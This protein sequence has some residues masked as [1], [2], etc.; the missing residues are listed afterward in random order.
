MVRSIR[1][2]A[3][4]SRQ[5]RSV[6]GRVQCWCFGGWRG[7]RA[8]GPRTKRPLLA[9]RRDAAGSVLA[10]CNSSGVD[11]CQGYY[12]PSRDQVPSGGARLRWRP[13]ASSRPTGGAAY[14]W[15]LIAPFYRLRCDG[16]RLA[17]GMEVYPTIEVVN[18]LYA[19]RARSAGL[20]SA[21]GFDREDLAPGAGGQVRHAGRLPRRPAHRA[22]GADAAPG[23]NWFDIVP[24]QD[25]LAVADGLGRP[26][27][28]SAA[29]WKRP[30]QGP[31]PTFFSV[32]RRL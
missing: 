24:G 15:L 19:R 1:R 31:D 5:S 14:G 2:P 16:I 30:D 11:H 6:A 4:R 26:M 17:E 32:L 8:A 28:I 13:T 22:A 7:G 20:Q 9:S 21:I 12:Q 23:Q 25:P 3:T 18:R 10:A 29:G 27:A